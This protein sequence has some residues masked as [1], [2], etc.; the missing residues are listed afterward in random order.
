MKTK[1]ELQELKDNWLS[2]PVYDI[3]PKTQIDR[4][5]RTIESLNNFEAYKIIM[6]YD[7]E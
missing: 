1:E 3:N 2:D 6:G 5:Q 7:E 4:L